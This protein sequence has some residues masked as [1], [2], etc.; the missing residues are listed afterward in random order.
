GSAVAAASCRRRQAPRIRG[1]V[2]VS[3]HVWPVARIEEALALVGGAAPD[4]TTFH[5]IAA[6][7]EGQRD[8]EPWLYAAAAARDL[9]A[10][11]LRVRGGDLEACLRDAAPALIV[12]LMGVIA[13]RR[14][15]GRRAVLVAPDGSDV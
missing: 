8:L 4:R 15:R 12:V 6:A 9:E 11:P 13:I 2:G 3:A 14:V 10:S 1:G 5:A 7:M